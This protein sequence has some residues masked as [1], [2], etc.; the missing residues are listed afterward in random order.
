MR[1]GYVLY[2]KD[3]D[4]CADHKAHGSNIFDHLVPHKEFS[5]FDM[6]NK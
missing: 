5:L 1:Q 4:V 2:R 6:V 3:I